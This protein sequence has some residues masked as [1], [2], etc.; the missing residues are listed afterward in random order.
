MKASN[1]ER[2]AEATIKER[3]G[4]EVRGIAYS[5]WNFDYP[6]YLPRSIIHL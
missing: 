5:L 3:P 4:F 1:G 2:V 6:N